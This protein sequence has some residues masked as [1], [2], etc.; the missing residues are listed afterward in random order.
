M[1]N[2]ITED[3]IN[4][5]Y[6]FHPNVIETIRA[7]AEGLAAAPKEDIKELQNY[8]ADEI[9]KYLTNLILIKETK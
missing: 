2:L 5:T 4:K 9:T 8:S 7:V 1:I 3:R 6:K